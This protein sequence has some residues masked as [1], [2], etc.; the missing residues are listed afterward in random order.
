[1]AKYLV[2][3]KYKVQ[4][5]NMRDVELWLLDNHPEEYFSGS[6]TQIGGTDFTI[7]AVREYY[8]EVFGTTDTKELVSKIKNAISNLKEVKECHDWEYDD[9]YGGDYSEC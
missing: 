6:I 3:K 9:I 8:E 1:M 4:A 2:N 5:K 7:M